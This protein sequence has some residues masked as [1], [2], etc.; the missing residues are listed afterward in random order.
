MQIQ[1]E[2]KKSSGNKD[3]LTSSD[4]ES[5]GPNSKKTLQMIKSV[6]IHEEE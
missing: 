6:G 1:A 5:D 4:D 2:F 3:A